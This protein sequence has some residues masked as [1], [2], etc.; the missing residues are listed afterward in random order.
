MSEPKAKVRLAKWADRH[1][2]FQMWR[3]L[4]EVQHSLGSIVLPTDRNLRE[5]GQL[6]ES[7][8]V[9]SLFGF[10]IVAEVVDK[11]V[12]F[13]M[14]GEDAGGLDVETN[15]GRT[16]II[17]GTWVDPAW[18]R[19]GISHRMLDLGYQEAYQMGFRCVMTSVLLSSKEASAN[20]FNYPGVKAYSTMVYNKLE[21][22]HAPSAPSRFR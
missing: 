13:G 2:F 19:R 15:L 8:T 6:F 7:Y 16:G 12:G 11:P 18:R 9:G 5:F 3:P 1:T 4:L 20:A 14:F 17:W 22:N 10:G 21:V